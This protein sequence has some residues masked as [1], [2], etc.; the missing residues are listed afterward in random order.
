MMP[1]G[2]GEGYRPDHLLCPPER[3]SMDNMIQ[4]FLQNGGVSLFFLFT[5]ELEELSWGRKVKLSN[6]QG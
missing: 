4:G 1:Q 2:G 6:L 5:S 3:Q